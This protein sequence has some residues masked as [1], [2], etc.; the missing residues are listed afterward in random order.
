MRNINLIAGTMVF[1]SMTLGCKK[2]NLTEKIENNSNVEIT[3]TTILVNPYENIELSYYEF[4]HKL[5]FEIPY[6]NKSDIEIKEIIDSSGFMYNINITQSEKDV[7]SNYFTTDTLNYSGLIGFEQ[8]VLNDATLK[9]NNLLLKSIA[10]AKANYHF[11]G[12]MNDRKDPPTFEEC[13]TDCIEKKVDEVFLYGNLYDQLQYIAGLPGS[14]LHFVGSC[15]YDCASFRPI[16]NGDA[17][18]NNDQN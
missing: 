2:A 8:Y 11:F 13:L 15:T 7:Y 14:F 12:D 4:L 1:F 17:P 9:Q 10:L 5:A 6:T 18:V 16:N 3:S